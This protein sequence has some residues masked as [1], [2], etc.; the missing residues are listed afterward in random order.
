ML[1]SL[2]QI[3]DHKGSVALTPI[4]FEALAKSAVSFAAPSL[5]DSKQEAMKK[6]VSWLLKQHDISERIDRA[7]P[8]YFFE[9]DSRKVLIFHTAA[10]SPESLARTKEEYKRLFPLK[11]IEFVQKDSADIKLKYNVLRDQY[12]IESVSKLT[13]K[14]R[15]E[16]AMRDESYKD[17]MAVLI[18]PNLLIFTPQE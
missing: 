9:R 4:K 11:E 1:L 15:D 13:D 14:F 7:I 6:E 2:R 3:R 8:S 12:K 17:A 16:M 18:Y 10:D 5:L